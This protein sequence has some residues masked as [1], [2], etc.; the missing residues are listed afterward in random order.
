MSFQINGNNPLNSG[1]TTP[2]TGSIVGMVARLVVTAIGLS[3]VAFGLIFL[4]MMGV[5]ENQYDKLA[6]TGGKTVAVVTSI[7]QE[8]ETKTSGTGSSRRTSTTTY[9]N[10]TLTYK[11]DGREFTIKDR[12]IKGNTPARM[13]EQQ[14]VF[15]D[16]S[17]P[18]T[19]V[20]EGSTTKGS[21]FKFIPIIFIGIG[22][23]MAF[24]GIFSLIRRRLHGRA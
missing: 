9:E 20:I 5:A 4:S 19:A 23:L 8:K 11:V 13:G 21:P 16:K 15:Y 17:N 7:K 1:N 22:G 2:S 3:T 14:N 12:D 18:S 10:K 6:S 24:G